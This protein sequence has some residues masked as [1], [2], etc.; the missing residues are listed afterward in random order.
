MGS[1]RQT[2]IEANLQLNWL[3]NRLSSCPLSLEDK[4][5]TNHASLDQP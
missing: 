2:L 3:V 4:E 1:I 5:G